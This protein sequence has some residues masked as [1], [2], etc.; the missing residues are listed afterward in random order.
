MA[1]V[2]RSGGNN[3]CIGYYA[4]MVSGINNIAIGY[5]VGR[6]TRLM[7]LVLSS[8]EFKVAVLTRHKKICSKFVDNLEIRCELVNNK[9]KEHLFMECPFYS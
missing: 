7:R 3:V 8:D 4:G 1:Y 6:D 2:I 5:S 9:L